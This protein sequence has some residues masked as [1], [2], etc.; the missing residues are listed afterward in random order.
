MTTTDY[1]SLTEQGWAVVSQGMPLC[2]PRKTRAE[3]ELVARHYKIDLPDVTWNGTVG[4][5]VVTDTIE[6]TPGA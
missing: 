1:L 3:A 6:D 2:A 5:W 4:R